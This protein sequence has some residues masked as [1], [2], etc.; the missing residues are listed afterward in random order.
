MIKSRWIEI[1]GKSHT[2]RISR[3]PIK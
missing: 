3:F 2:L 1:N